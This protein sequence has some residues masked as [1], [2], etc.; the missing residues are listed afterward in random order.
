MKPVRDEKLLNTDDEGVEAPTAEDA[1]VVVDVDDC[2]NKRERAEFAGIRVLECGNELLRRDDKPLDTPVPAPCLDGARGWPCNPSIGPDELVFW[3]D[4]RIAAIL[5]EILPLLDADSGSV[6]GGVTRDS[7]VTE[8]AVVS[9][10][11]AGME[12]V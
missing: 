11:D 9:E 2:S 10:T 7:V 4:S 8:G 5:D 3:I 12:G 1:G 6:L